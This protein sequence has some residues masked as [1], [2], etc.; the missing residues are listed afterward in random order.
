MKSI[1]K[2]IIP[3]KIFSVYYYL[4]AL[5]GAC[6]Y[7][8]PS[9]KLI[10]IGVT[11]TKGKTTTSNLIWSVLMAGGIKCGIIS[12]ANIKIGNVEEVN[13]LHMT[14]P[15]RFI[16]Q[17]YLSKMV[18]EGCK[19]AIV[20]TTSQGLAQS[21]HIGID[22]DVAVL[23]NL[24]AEHIESHGS[25][26]NYK[27]AKGILFESLL[28]SKD[29]NFEGVPFRK[30]VI[31]NSDSDHAPFYL[32]FHAPRQITFGINKEADIKVK[33]IL[34]GSPVTFEVGE[35][36]YE[37]GL[38]GKFNIINALPAIALGKLF[39][40]KEEQI[41][42]GLKTLS[43]VP[44]R[45]EQIN[46]GQHFKVFVDYAHEK[47]SMTLATEAVRVMA[48]SVGKTIILLGAEGGGRDR[49]KRPLMGEAV[50]KGADYVVVANVDPY[51]GDPA[52][53]AEEIAIA[54]EKEGKIRGK[55]LF[56]I[57]DRREGIR[58]AL[59]LA[60]SRE[61]IVLITG[62]GAEQTMVINNE[63]I[64]W[65]DRVIVREELSKLIKKNS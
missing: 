29:K 34:G 49:A 54:A 60:T 52:P 10:I 38:P 18:Q 4:F 35:I 24:F 12:T 25:F 15:G 61:D 65:D 57:L 42:E 8:F 22:F 37:M 39:S 53:I 14:M 27:K 36:N 64:K 63:T 33:N 31:V 7:G 16:I 9:K 41:Q 48:G 45:M 5:L 17:K 32:S 58:K 13:G 28:K 6:F 50:G 1:L 43:L 46:E 20:E 56:V 19:V 30:T 47:E 11:G 21:R 40:I 23:T 44:G 3:K 59:S 62:K 51:D 26:E 55:D 2:K